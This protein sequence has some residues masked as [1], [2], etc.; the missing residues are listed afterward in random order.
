MIRHAYEAQGFLVRDSLVD[1]GELRRV[2]ALLERLFAAR[3]GEA[4]GD[5]LDLLGDDAPE[6]PELLPQLLMPCT[7]AP[8]LVGPL[9]AAVRRLAETLLGPGLVAEGE[10]AILKP[11][12]VGPAV[13]LHQDEAYWS[14]Q[15]D[16][17]SLSVWVPLVDVDVDSG[18]MAYVP[19][20]HRGEIHAHHSVGG[21]RRNNSLEI[22]GPERFAATPV[23]LAAGGA[24]VH[25]CRTIH[26]STANLTGRPRLAYVFGFGLPARPSAA[27]RDFFWQRDRELRREAL[28]AVGGYELTRMHPEL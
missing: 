5:R 18:C 12:R 25:H 19:G 20:S 27:P 11:A 24:I 9:H 16:Y 6:R 10:H 26:G 17:C 1:A 13:P 21:D 22:D 14:P 8:E 23:P 7:Y 4:R 3:A 2:R 28:A 15:T